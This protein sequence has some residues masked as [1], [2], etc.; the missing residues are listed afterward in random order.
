MKLF[1]GPSRSQVLISHLRVTPLLLNPRCPVFASWST[2]CT[3]PPVT[4]HSFSVSCPICVPRHNMQTSKDLST[5]LKEKKES[6][7]NAVCTGRPFPR[8]EFGDW[9]LSGSRN[10]P[11]GCGL[12]DCCVSLRSC[13]KKRIR[14][15]E[16]L[17]AHKGKC[18]SI[19]RN[20]VIRM[21]AL[22]LFNV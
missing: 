9:D 4:R 6:Q 16:R 22:G 13:N 17:D 21:N 10:K 2:Q 11:P 5:Q 18:C 1:F 14:T 15:W 7:E 3:L 8:S 12:P 19:E 20:A